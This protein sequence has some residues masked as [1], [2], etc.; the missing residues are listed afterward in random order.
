MWTVWLDLLDTVSKL[1]FSVGFD[2][3]LEVLLEQEIGPGFPDEEFVPCTGLL[4]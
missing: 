4:I 3:H 2:H 1:S